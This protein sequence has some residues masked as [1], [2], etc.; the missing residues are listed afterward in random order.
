MAVAPLTKIH[1]QA[2]GSLIIQATLRLRPRRQGGLGDPVGGLAMLRTLKPDQ[3]IEAAMEVHEREGAVVCYTNKTRH[4]IN[5]AV[6]SCFGYNAAPARGEP[7]LMMRNCRA[8]DRYNGEVVP[9]EEW[10]SPPMEWIAEHPLLPVPRT[11]HFQAARLDGHKV[12]VCPEQLF[13]RTDVPDWLL[14]D[15]AEVCATRHD[16]GLWTKDDSAKNGE[17]LIPFP[18]VS[19]NLGWVATTHKM[20]GSQASHVLFVL[21]WM[22]S[23]NLAQDEEMQRLVYTALTRA[24]KEVI[25]C[26]YNSFKPLRMPVRRAV[27]KAATPPPYKALFVPEDPGAA[28]ELQ[29]KLGASAKLCFDRVALQI[30]DEFEAQQIMID[31]DGLVLGKGSV[32]VD[33]GMDEL[34][35][36]RGRGLWVDAL[37]NAAWT[38]G[39]TV[40]AWHGPDA[41]KGVAEGGYVT[42]PRPE[43]WVSTA[44]PRERGKKTIFSDP[45][46]AP[47]PVGGI[48]APAV[49]AVRVELPPTPAVVSPIPPA[50][51]PASEHP[52]VAPLASTL[53]T[54]PG[55]PHLRL[56]PPEDT[57]A[58]ATPPFPDPVELT[59][60]I[61]PCRGDDGTSRGEDAATALHLFHPG[62]AVQQA[63]GIPWKK[64]DSYPKAMAWAA[65]VFAGVV[66]PAA[67]VELLPDGT[68]RVWIGRGQLDFANQFAQQGKSVAIYIEGRL[69]R[70]AGASKVPAKRGEGNPRRCA[71]VTVRGEMGEL[72]GERPA[73][74]ASSQPGLADVTQHY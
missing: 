19:A 27:L 53:H 68:R 69:Y 49:S 41:A 24:E 47:T 33:R 55:T 21:E 71:V 36:G 57:P 51:I 50:M 54:L 15:A 35:I 74:A 18:F 12:L 67:E 6:R 17:I 64:M 40:L 65:R 25:V 45:M 38:A 56:V 66:L 62:L 70:Y 2:E 13:G 63:E 48:S 3:L 1:R 7:F 14:E 60:L 28:G 52:P 9:F 26:P 4:A 73:G 42:L 43:G 11:V 59:F 10:L 16:L 46:T 37:R 32:G 30:S 8:I 23:K 22:V 72:L 61:A 31:Y 20:Q 58:P 39:K 34:E 44:V 29:K 5:F